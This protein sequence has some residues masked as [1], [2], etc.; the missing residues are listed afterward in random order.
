MAAHSNTD[1]S[2][3]SPRTGTSWEINQQ[4]KQNAVALK[5]HLKKA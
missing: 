3:Q 4:S 5:R 1:I 2:H